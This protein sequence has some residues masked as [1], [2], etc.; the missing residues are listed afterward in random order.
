M[1]KILIVD[2]EES[3]LLSLTDMF[4]TC[5]EQFDIQ[6]AGNGK[7][8]IEA[9]EKDSFNLVVTDLKMPE[10]DGF[11]LLAHMSK[12]HP[13]IPVIAMTAFGTPEMEDQILDLGAFQYIEKPIEFDL[14]LKKITDGLDAGTKGH[15]AGISIGS[16]LQLLELERKTCTLTV[17]AGELNGVIY[18]KQGDLINAIIGDSEEGLEAA[19]E[20]LCWDNTSIEIV[21]MCRKRKRVIEVPLGYLLIEGARK[22]DEM[23]HPPEDAEREAGEAVETEPPPP[24]ESEENLNTDDMDFDTSGGPP[25]P[26]DEAKPTPAFVMEEVSVFDDVQSADQLYEAVQSLEGVNKT[27]LLARDG[28][29]LSKITPDDKKFGDFVSLVATTA[30]SLAKLMGF[31][32][33]KHVV[34]NQKTGDKLAVMTGPHIF[35][36]LEISKGASPPDIADSIRPAINKIAAN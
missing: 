23:E 30:E 11:G 2:D 28:S 25:A 24:E 17:T 13:D 4:K 22:K 15:V 29:L 9:L 26:A 20:I 34:L 19:L 36:G 31:Q 27:V 1:K 21:N 12:K 33:L 32:E 35:L 14:L 8:A 18:F 10:V 7:E 6:T 5:D 3:F 16:F